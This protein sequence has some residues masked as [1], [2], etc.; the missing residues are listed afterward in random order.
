MKLSEAIRAG[1]SPDPLDAAM[2]AIGG[3]I[4]RVEKYLRVY[5]IFGAR[6]GHIIIYKKDG[7]EH[8]YVK[9]KDTQAFP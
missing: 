1:A 3:Y 7:Y 5:T 2:L 6:T 9:P 8:F 4:N